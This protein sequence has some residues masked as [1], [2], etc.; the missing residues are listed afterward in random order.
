MGEGPH[1]VCSAG[2]QSRALGVD[3]LEGGKAGSLKI[4]S[5]QF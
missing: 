5:T 3:V 2:G 4:P 1:V